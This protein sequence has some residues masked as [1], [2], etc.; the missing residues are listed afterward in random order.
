MGK[1][2]F[3]TFLSELPKDLKGIVPDTLSKSYDY[4]KSSYD[5]Y[6]ENLLFQYNLDNSIGKNV[7]IYCKCIRKGAFIEGTTLSYILTVYGVLLENNRIS[8]LSTFLDSNLLEKGIYLLTIDESV[9]YLGSFELCKIQNNKIIENIDI[10]KIYITTTIY[11]VDLHD[12]FARF[13]WNFL[14]KYFLKN[15]L[16]NIILS[17]LSD[18]NGELLLF[19]IYICKSNY[20]NLLNDSN[21]ILDASNKRNI[22]TTEVSNE[23]KIINNEIQNIKIYKS[24]QKEFNT[25]NNITFINRTSNKIL[26]SIQVNKILIYKFIV[27]NG[28]VKFYI[29]NNIRD[30][31][32]YYIVQEG[33]KTQHK[34]YNFNR[35]YCKNFYDITEDKLYGEF[36]DKSDQFQ[37]VIM[38]Y[39]ILDDDEDDHYTS[40]QYHKNKKDNFEGMD[41]LL[42]H[43]DVYLEYF[44]ECYQM[45]RICNLIA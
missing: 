28:K 36:N 10:G 40:E 20:L 43:N 13:I 32:K 8:V 18:D 19:L 42:D 33:N 21:L 14:K 34:L 31:L 38:D 7:Y 29:Y 6:F 25:Y 3:T 1:S 11:N 4:L 39:I 27:R 15:D 2:Y 9:S 35:L 45:G 26:I 37:I 16:N 44:Y 12:Y 23:E 24:T 17:G 5:L 41:T 30:S 22:K